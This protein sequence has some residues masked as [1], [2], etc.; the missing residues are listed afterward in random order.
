MTTLEPHPIDES[1]LI[2][3]L[4]VY[5]AA[6]YR[7]QY[8]DDWHDIVIGL[9]TPGLDLRYPEAPSYGLISAWNPLSVAK[10]GAENR[11]A[12]R[13]LEARLAATGLPHIPAFASAAD[14]SWREP[15][16]IVFGMEAPAFD[17]LGREFAQLGTLWWRS[18]QPVRLRIDAARPAG[19]EGDRH[20]DWLR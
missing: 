2:A 5:L 17:A 8:R 13:Q 14:R 9:P 20:V 10:S 7:W 3:L 6:R 18:G 12:D 1:R 16:W 19:I 11:R 4:H 15:S